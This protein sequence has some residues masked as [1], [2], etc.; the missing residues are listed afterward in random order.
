MLQKTHGSWLSAL[1]SGKQGNRWRGKS[2]ADGM[3]KANSALNFSIMWN[4]LLG[5]VMIFLS[6][7]GLSFLLL[8]PNDSW[9]RYLKSIVKNN[10][11]TNTVLSLADRLC[12]YASICKHKLV[13]HLKFFQNIFCVRYSLP[14]NLTNTSFQNYGWQKAK[15]QQ[16]PWMSLTI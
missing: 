11:H 8:Q 16:R 9:Y 6:Q 12:Q 4:N 10:S 5:F 1:L 13:F 14:Y 15:K 2:D 3:P 7:F